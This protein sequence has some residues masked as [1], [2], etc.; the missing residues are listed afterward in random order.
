VLPTCERRGGALGEQAEEGGEVQADGDARQAL[1]VAGEAAGA[2]EPGEGALG[3][4]AA[5]SRTKPR[6]ASGNFTTRT[7]MP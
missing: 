4:P 3:D 6:L 5:G 1:V 2:A 7:S